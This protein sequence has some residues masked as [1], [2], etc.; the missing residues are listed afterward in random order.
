MGYLSHNPLRSALDLL[1]INTTNMRIRIVH[2][3]VL[4]CKHIHSINAH[5]LYT[6][7]RCLL[8]AFIH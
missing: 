2:I 1:C 6:C 5:V 4:S 3:I 8:N 7:C